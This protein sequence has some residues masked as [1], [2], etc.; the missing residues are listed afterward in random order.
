MPCRKECAAMGPLYVSQL[1]SLKW[2]RQGKVRDIYEV[3]ARHL[4]IVATDRLS[5]FDVVLPTPIPD[6]GRILTAMSN[7]WFVRMAGVSTDGQHLWYSPSCGA[8]RIGAPAGAPLY[9]VDKSSTGGTRHQ[10]PL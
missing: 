10:H 4:L 9:P 3:D 6:K 5:A 7:F 2:L 8:A 1:P